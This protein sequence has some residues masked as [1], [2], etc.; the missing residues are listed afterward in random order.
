LDFDYDNKLQISAIGNRSM[1]GIPP[2]IICS[3]SRDINN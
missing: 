1:S 2:E 3:A